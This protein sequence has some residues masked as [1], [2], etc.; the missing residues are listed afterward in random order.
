MAKLMD[1]RVFRS[2]DGATPSHQ[3]YIDTCKGEEKT[4]EVTIKEDTEL[5]KAMQICMAFPF[6]L[7]A[8]YLFV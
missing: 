6:T 2:C 4:L 5:E 1:A 7:L 8:L 3:S